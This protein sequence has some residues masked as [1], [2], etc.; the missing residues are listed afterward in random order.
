MASTAQHEGTTHH[1]PRRLPAAG[2]MLAF[3]RSLHSVDSAHSVPST[4]APPAKHPVRLTRRGRVVVLLTLLVLLLVAFV[5]GRAGTSE[6][7]TH[8]PGTARTY[9]QTTVHQGESLWAVARRVAPGSD[10]R[11]LVLRIQELNHLDS[12]SVQA[13][14]QLLLPTT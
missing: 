4:P 13:G 11:S 5:L 8:V 1:I 12:G 7:A 3:E 10:P 9:S 6:A 2:P 14:Q